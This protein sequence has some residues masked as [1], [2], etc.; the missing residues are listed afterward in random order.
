MKLYKYLGTVSYLHIGVNV[1]YVAYNSMWKKFIIR[2]FS[3]NLIKYNLFIF[4]V[5][6]LFLCTTLMSL[7]MI[8]KRD[9]CCT[10]SFILPT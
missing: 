2:A 9:F 5:L 1:Y 3:C 10:I 7:M 8:N 6:L 4:K